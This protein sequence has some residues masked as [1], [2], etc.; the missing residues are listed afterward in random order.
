ML[1][2]VK[3]AFNPGREQDLEDPEGGSWKEANLQLKIQKNLDLRTRRLKT[4][5]ISTRKERP[6]A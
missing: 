3:M 5:G 6:F 2:Q 1:S 4:P